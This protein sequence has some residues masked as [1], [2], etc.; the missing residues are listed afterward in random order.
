MSVNIPGLCSVVGFYLIILITG[1]I[2]G[3]KTAKSGTKE[4]IILA[5]RSMGVLL[6]FFTLTATNI[7][8][9]Y[10]NGTAESIAFDGLL[11]TQAPVCYCIA[12]TIAGVV[13]APKVRKAGYVTMFDPFQLKYGRKV[14]ALLFLPQ[15]LSDMFWAASVLA[16]LGNTV[17]V[18]LNFDAMWSTIISAAV[19]IVYTFLGGLYSVAYTDVI[20]LLFI[21]GGLY[22]VFPF[23]WTNDAVDLS[24]VSDTWLGTIPP[25]YIGMYMDIAFLL[26]MGGLPW[27][28]YYQRVLA[29][30]N[31]KIARNSTIMC[32]VFS[33][34]LSLPP[35]FIGIAGAAADW[36]QTLYTGEVPLPESRRSFVLPLAMQYLCP[37]PVSIIGI[38]AVS[39]AVMSSADSCILASASVFT[40]N[41]Y[42]D[43]IRP[44]ASDREMVWLLRVSVIVVG[45]LATLIACTANSVY[46][47]FV[48][49]S[50]LMYVIL[51]P[52]FTLVL[53]FTQSNAYGCLAGYSVAFLLRVLGGEPLIGLPAL[54]RF[55]LYDEAAGQ[56]FPF[57]TFSMLCNCAVTISVSLL[58]NAMFFR[59][60]VPAKYDKLNCLRQRTIEFL[61]K[62]ELEPMADDTRVTAPEKGD[63]PEV[64]RRAVKPGSLLTE[65]RDGGNEK[66]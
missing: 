62:H 45:S 10:I 48:L 28:V 11:W 15:M 17:A 40:K 13:Y 6:S 52:Q 7:G 27:Q 9:G 2:A 39:A 42:C 60:W 16:A 38:G 31:Y 8:G 4:D 56:L 58:T 47:L 65:E 44:K 57:R 24:R 12:V 21:A 1:I 46:G 26:I 63:H 29:C 32:A 5:D 61:D 25:N 18:I 23:T 50:D 36:N 22:L 66:L 19:V 51:F 49:C 3:R 43:I 33:F 54:L 30:K 59:G 14:G 34:F 64:A 20:Q 55:P 35:A 41:I 53:W 37:L